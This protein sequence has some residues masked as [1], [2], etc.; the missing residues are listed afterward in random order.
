MQAVRASLGA[1]EDVA[2]GTVPALPFDALERP[3]VMFT[4]AKCPAMFKSLAQLLEHQ[5]CHEKETR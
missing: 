1:T 5:R 3:K 4:C 2:A